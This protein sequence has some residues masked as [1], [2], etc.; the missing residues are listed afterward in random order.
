MGG[1]LPN[2]S[3]STEDKEKDAALTTAFKLTQTLRQAGR[4]APKRVRNITWEAA[5]PNSGFT[6]DMEEYTALTTAL[7]LT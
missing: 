2:N 1:H 6:E 5:C 3:G 4:V 7:A